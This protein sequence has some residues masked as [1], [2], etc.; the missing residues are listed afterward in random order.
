M[1]R[2]YVIT[3]GTGFI[4][5]RVLKH[6]LNETSS[7]VIAL[8]RNKEALVDIGPPD[9]G[10]PGIASLGIG[11]RCTIITADI[12]QLELSDWQ[13]ILS[14]ATDVI[15][16]AWCT[17]GPNPYQSFEN[18]H[19]METSFR[20]GRAAL[21][22]KVERF[23]GLGTCLEYGHLSIPANLDTP[24]APQSVYAK[25]KAAA[26]LG[27][28]ALFSSAPI[29]FAWYRLYQVFHE[30]EP[31]SKLIPYLHEQLKNGQQA[32]LSPGE[33]VRDFIHVNQAAK[34]I[35]QLHNSGYQ[36]SANI[37]TGFGMSVREKCIEIAR[38]YRSEALLKFGESK[39]HPDD[40]PYLV[41]VPT[42]P[43]NA[44]A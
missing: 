6:I 3:G 12:T 44:R 15:H 10:T 4:G 22:A 23:S 33:Q 8:T 37:C 29:L 9:I 39:P 42:L 1:T 13:E 40:P 2:T 36:G 11:P 27:L 34:R 7:P 43:N 24:L 21:E 14:K 28:S 38:S 5:K 25:S 16:A 41:G 35:W 19:H 30:S 18:L 20:I 31:R 26:F 17:Q 32:H